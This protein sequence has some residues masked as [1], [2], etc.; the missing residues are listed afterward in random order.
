MVRLMQKDVRLA[1]GQIITGFSFGGWT[2]GDGVRIVVSTL[3]PA[4]GTNRLVEV[5]PGMRP[6]FRK[7]EFTRFV[8]SPAK[9]GAL[10]R[11][12]ALGIEPMVVRLDRKSPSSDQRH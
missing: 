8:L 7:R 11:V 1:D 10:M 2:E 3:V 6:S 5:T 9:S 12:K 4:D